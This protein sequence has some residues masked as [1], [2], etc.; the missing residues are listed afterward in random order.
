MTSVWHMPSNCVCPKGA[1]NLGE[2]DRMQMAPNDQSDYVQRLEQRIKLLEQVIDNFPGG[3]LLFNQELELVLCN[4]QQKL[5]LQYPDELFESGPPTLEELFAYNA[6]R[7]EYGPGEAFEQV[8]IR[9]QLAKEGRAHIFERTRPNGTILE[10][11]GT[12]LEGGGFVTTYFDVTEQ[13]KNQV[14]I[15]HMAHHDLLTNLP[16]RTLLLQTLE[17][18]TARVGQGDELA[19]LFI[20]LDRF[21]PVN[22]R[23]GHAVGDMLLKE[24]ADRLRAATRKVDTIAR[25]GGDEF[26]VV[27]TG[28]DNCQDVDIVASRI[29]IAIAEPFMIEGIAIEISAS[30]GITM[31]PRDGTEPDHLMKNAD[32][33]MYRSKAEKRGVYSFFDGPVRSEAL[34]EARRELSQDIRSMESSR[35][36]KEDLV[37]KQSHSAIR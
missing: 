27:L 13:R 20:D 19:V 15:A 6:Q 8:K 25:I 31:S 17:Q 14:L 11:R 32:T 12:P 1:S 30:I 33:A 10:V 36:A 29:L 23:Y 28:A 7:G 22:D 16:N 24:V 35:P 26:V 34:T 37:C 5:L 9:M 4:A 18:A 2:D 3:I 21:K